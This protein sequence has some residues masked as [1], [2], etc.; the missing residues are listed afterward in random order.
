MY[1]V[2]LKHVGVGSGVRGE[3]LEEVASDP[4]C[5]QYF[6]LD[7]GFDEIDAL[8]SSITRK[9]CDGMLYIG[10]YNSYGV[11]HCKNIWT[12]SHI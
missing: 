7:D 5:M 9:A 1:I 10:V 3:E 12:V 2:L 4:K 6:Q 8:V 11:W